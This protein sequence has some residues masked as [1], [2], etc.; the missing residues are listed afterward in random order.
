MKQLKFFLVGSLFFLLFVLFSYLVHKDFFTQ[1]DFNATVRLQD[2][3]SRRFDPY[4]SILS[5][6]GTFEVMLGLLVIIL[7]L[8][9]KIRG[10]V[11]FGLFGIFHLIELYGKFFVEHLPPPE[12]L[13][14]TESLIDFPQFHIRSENSYPS[15]HAGRAAFL[16]L[17]IGLIVLRS[18]KFSRVQK[19]FI[20]GVLATYDITMFVSR[21]YL[22]EH[23]A[24][25]VIGG[26]LLGISM[27]VLSVIFI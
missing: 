15:G 23:W 10:V 13:L 19:T 18:K 2:N 11:V 27:A 7:F 4:F 5:D 12:F 17:F 6:I 21:I 9:R 20:I 25:D 22:G 14:R 3:I 1:F 16:T 26:T 8:L 24:T